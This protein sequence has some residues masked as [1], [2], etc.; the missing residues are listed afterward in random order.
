[1]SISTTSG[2]QAVG[3]DHRLLT[4]GGLT[5]DGCLRLALE[6]LAQPDTHERLVVCDQDVRHLIG[7]STRT[8]KPPLGR[9]SAWSTPP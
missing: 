9:G 6:D 2:A 4:V 8:V 1:M 3:L 5:D 7:S